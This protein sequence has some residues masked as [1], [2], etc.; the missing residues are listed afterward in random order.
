MKVITSSNNISGE[1][2]FVYFYGPR[3]CANGCSPGNQEINTAVNLSAS[4]PLNVSPLP[5]AIWRMLQME[6]VIVSNC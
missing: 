5:Q 6:I 3:G 2:W 4:F 1:R